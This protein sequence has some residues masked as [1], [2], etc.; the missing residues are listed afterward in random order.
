MKN[1][2]DFALSATVSPEFVEK[3]V[4]EAI[5]ARTG[6]K[7]INITFTT[8]EVSDYMDRYSRTVFNGCS[9]TFDAKD[10]N[11]QG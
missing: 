9:V 6:R 10:V 4:R 7:V 8:R 2:F 11:G 5:E 3:V 1:D